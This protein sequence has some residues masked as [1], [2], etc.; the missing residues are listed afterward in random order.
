MNEQTQYLTNSLVEQLALMA[1]KDYGL[2][3]VDAL[4]L[5][6]H[7]QWY[8]KVTDTETGLYFQSPAYN[9]RLLRHEVAFGKVN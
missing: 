6:Y 3:M 4:A 5:V 8:E 2:T 7:S 9:Y 1:M